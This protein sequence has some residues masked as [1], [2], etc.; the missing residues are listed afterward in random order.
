M[1]PSQNAI[2]YV[3]ITLST[4]RRI[5]KSSARVFATS[6]RS[7]TE[8]SRAAAPNQL[9]IARISVFFLKRACLHARFASAVETYDA[10]FPRK[11]GF[12]V[13]I[14]TAKAGNAGC[15]LRELPERKIQTEG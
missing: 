5:T 8:F 15:C 10:V 13:I 11:N 2:L 12:G 1:S 9:R 7:I 4:R 14:P 3:R 6:L